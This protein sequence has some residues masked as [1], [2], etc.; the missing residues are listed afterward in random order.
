MQMEMPKE[1]I[2]CNSPIK[3][4]YRENHTFRCSCEKC[5]D[6]S[7]ALTFWLSHRG[8]F[9]RQHELSGVS[10]LRNEYGYEELLLE[11]TYYEEFLKTGDPFIKIPTLVSEKINSF[12][13]YMRFK[14]KSFGKYIG[15]NHLNDYPL[16]FEDSHECVG[17]YLNH[18]IAEGYLM[19]RNDEGNVK[20]VILTVKAWDYLSEKNINS[21]QCFVAM[22]FDNAPELIQLFDEGIFTAVKRAGYVPFRVDKK[23]YDSTTTIDNRII[24]E[25]NRSRFMV[26]D[27][28]YNKQNVYYEA[29]YA[30]GLGIYL[31]YS[32]N[33]NFIDEVHFDIRNFPHITWEASKLSEFQD[34]LYFAIAANMNR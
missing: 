34:Q 3:S 10:R 22:S 11:E 28:T 33:K 1:C 12:L 32:C 26:A 18:L 2:L 7:F 31:I 8:G 29:G 17:Y 6:Y 27:F 20:N 25:I 13:E 15:I 30:R 14:S 24:S 19:H 23:D 5:G 9:D 4:E 21:K 16:F